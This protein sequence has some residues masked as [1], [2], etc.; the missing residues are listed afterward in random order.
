MVE[1]AKVV[2]P[3]GMALSVGTAFIEHTDLPGRASH[4]AEAWKQ[5]CEVTAFKRLVP[6]LRQAPPQTPVCVTSDALYASAPAIRL[7]AAQGWVYVFTLKPGHHRA[8]WAEFQ[9][10]P[11]SGADAA[12]HGT[13]WHPASV[14]LGHRRDGGGERRTPVSL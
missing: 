5:D 8:A 6:A 10:R 7:V 2:G 1:E 13:G 4:D 14:S 11:L 12:R 3:A 9:S